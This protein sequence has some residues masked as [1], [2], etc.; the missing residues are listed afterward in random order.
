MLYNFY[1]YYLNNYLSKASGR[2]DTHKKSEL[3]NVCNAI[4]KLNT[5]SPLY[6]I[7]MSDELQNNV[8]DIKEHARSLRNIITS[9]TENENKETFR[10]FN[11]KIPTSSDETAIQVNY[12]GNESDIENAPSFKVEI[13]ELATPQVNKGNYLYKNSRTLSSNTYSF[14]V[15]I[16]N[17]NYEFQFLVKDTETNEDILTKVS[18]MLNRADIGIYSTIESNESGEKQRLVLSSTATG[19]TFFSDNLFQI[20]DSNTSMA[21]GSVK[22]LGLN[23]VEQRATDSKFTI[24]GV[25][26]S[27]S[28]NTF[29]VNKTY[30]FNLLRTTQPDEAI[31]ICFKNDKNST[32]SKISEFVDTY[33]DMIALA[34][35]TSSPS[36]KSLKLLADIGSIATCYKNELDSMGLMVQEDSTIQIDETL[37]KQTI[38]TEEDGDGTFASFRSFREPLNRKIDYVLLNPIE[39]ISKTIVTYPNTQNHY[40]NAYASS[41]YSGLM[42]NN[43]C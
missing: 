25:P 8:I 14:N 22:Y 15:N 16:S 31:E 36:K 9:I 10:M 34:K 2:Y 30:E 28:S 7:K 40:L 12:V 5:E 27:S 43:Y 41:T 17:T 20:S 35:D 39:Y 3:R 38:D 13:N 19:S 37:L 24:N 6:I 23:L 21:S 29:T 1:N 33:N 42:F 18:N 32:F 11:D 4:V 26:R